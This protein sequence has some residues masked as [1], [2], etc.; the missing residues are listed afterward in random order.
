ML[1]KITR[2]I[3]FTCLMLPLLVYAGNES[4][5]GG[6]DDIGIEFQS[7][8]IR[9]LDEISTL[10][11]KLSAKLKPL[12]LESIYAPGSG[13][14]LVIDEEQELTVEGKK[15]SCVALSYPDKMK[16]TITRKRW[17]SIKSI[18]VKQAI[19]LHEALVLKKIEGTGHYQLS[20][21]Y[22]SY[23]NL[24]GESVVTGVPDLKKTSAPLAIHCAPSDLWKID[25]GTSVKNIYVVFNGKKGLSDPTIYFR[26]ATERGLPGFGLTA[27]K[28]HLDQEDQGKLSFLGG[29]SYL[30]G[31]R[32]SPLK[33]DKITLGFS[34]INIGSKGM[35]TATVRDD[36]E[37]APGL[38]PAQGPSYRLNCFVINELP[39]P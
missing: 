6:G 20:A 35:A 11:P 5:A 9:A 1:L 21:R 29:E 14:A 38:E 10:D 23:F 18:H 12:G 17:E 15:Q 16:T 36:S 28:G 7:L 32:I 3:L 4:S 37:K 34:K 27:Q 13:Q 30:V 33:L 39:K 26:F 25:S 24:A 31:G 19:A 2:S 22:L 8:I